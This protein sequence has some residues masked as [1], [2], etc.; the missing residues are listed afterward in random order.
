MRRRGRFA[1][2]SSTHVFWRIPAKGIAICSTASGVVYAGE[3]PCTGR[4][5]AAGPVG[6]ARWS[7]AN[8]HGWSQR[9]Q[10]FRGHAAA[11]G[12]PRFLRRRLRRGDAARAGDRADPARARRS[13]PR[14]RACSCARTSSS[15]TR[16]GCSASTSPRPS[17][18]WSSTSWPWWTSRRS[19]RA[20]A[21]PPPGTSGNLGCHH[22]ILGY[23]DPETQHEVWD[24]NPDALIASSIALAAGRGRQGGR[25]LRRQRP[26]AVL[27]RRSTTP[28]GT[29]SPSPSTATTA[30]RR[31]TGGC[32]WCPSPTTRS[33]TPGTPWAWR[34]RAARTSR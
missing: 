4:P 20:A 17:A 6:S 14:T 29:C 3:T 13:G 2:C 23:Y 7:E 31:S 5:R 12:A 10:Q 1:V 25:R 22:W 19:S 33:S 18:G 21:R 11:D 34:R 16:A 24:A 28:T 15:C 26:L 27:L 32:A 8:G 9:S 30:R